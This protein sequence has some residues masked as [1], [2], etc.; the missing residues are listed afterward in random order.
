MDIPDCQCWERSTTSEN[1]SKNAGLLPHR[2]R[3]ARGLLDILCTNTSRPA[4]GGGDGP[5]FSVLQPF[6][7]SGLAVSQPLSPT[8]PVHWGIFSWCRLFEVS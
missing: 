6:G 8:L 5:P 7:L 3:A 2:E 1:A 4:L